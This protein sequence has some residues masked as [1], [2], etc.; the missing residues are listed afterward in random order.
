MDKEQKREYMKTYNK[1]YREKN[2]QKIKELRQEYYLK[3]KDYVKTK[4]SNHYKTNG[5]NHK[6]NT[7][8][9]WRRRGVKNVDDVLYQHYQDTTS[10]SCC[11]KEFTSSTDKHLD[12]DHTTGNF[13][14]VICC[15][16]NTKDN[17]I[18]K[19]K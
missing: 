17:W 7:M 9:R 12:H 15:S 10:C 3:H 6:T 4:S 1:E 5:Y 16:C 14:W 18:N 13:R 19:L 8:S 2:K 11:G